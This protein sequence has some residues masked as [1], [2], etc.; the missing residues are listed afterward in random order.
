MTPL[1]IPRL[2]W[3][4]YLGNAPV[5]AAYRDL[6][7]LTSRKIVLH[8]RSLVLHVPQ[9]FYCAWKDAIHIFIEESSDR[10]HHSAVHELLHGILVEEG[11]CPGPTRLSFSPLTSE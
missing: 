4:D 11:Y 3:K 8:S 5:A 7:Q 9:S 10:V 6:K 2:K 1:D